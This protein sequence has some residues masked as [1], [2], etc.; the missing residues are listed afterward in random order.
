MSDALASAAYEI[1]LAIREEGAFA[2]ELK[3]TPNGQPTA[4]PEIIAAL[5]R[6]HPGY[7]TKE[8]QSAIAQGMHASR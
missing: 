5:R 7:E 6:L 1:C 2:E 4:C 3:R 8:Y